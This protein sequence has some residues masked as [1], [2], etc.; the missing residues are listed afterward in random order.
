MR[1]LNLA[2]ALRSRRTE[3]HFICRDEPGHLLDVI[4]ERGHIATALPN[5]S[6]FDGE[7]NSKGG[8]SDPAGPWLDLKADA[9]NT[10]NIL[11]KRPPDWLVVDHY[12]ID[13]NWEAELRSICRKILV[14]DDLA[15]RR[16]DCDLLV[17]GNVGRTPDDYLSLIPR[18]CVSLM[19]HQ[20][21]ML[22]S[23]CFLPPAEH[24]HGTIVFLGGGNNEGDLKRLIPIL[25]HCRLP[26]PVTVIFGR[27]QPNTAHL[28]N[29]C[30]ESGVQHIINPPDFKERCRSA[31]LAIVRC[32]QVSYELAAFQTP[33][34]CFWR[35]GIHEKVALWLERQGF[36]VATTLEEFV[37]DR[38]HVNNVERALR[39]KPKAQFQTE[40]GQLKLLN[41]MIS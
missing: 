9:H 19:G 25:P 2:D 21:V 11:A 8:H 33:S 6:V 38:E 4:R 17:D 27:N 30:N 41:H 16:H 36:V 18:S 28:I 12:D 5:E 3:C 1:C 20:Y 32:G 15:D 7:T 24:R 13:I 10:L 22:D 29:I 26:E 37:D 35:P 39:L 40:P 31:S 23:M 14:I 34:I